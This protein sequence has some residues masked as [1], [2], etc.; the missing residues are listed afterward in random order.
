MKSLLIII[1]T[2][3]FSIYISA[4]E[5]NH[6]LVVYF[7][8][9]DE[10]PYTIEKPSDFLTK[11]AIERREKYNIPI[12][13]SDLPVVPNYLE[14]LLSKKIALKIFYTSRWMN[15]AVVKPHSDWKLN[16]NQIWIK[17]V[18]EY[19]IISKSKT[20]SYDENMQPVFPHIYDTITNPY[21][22]QIKLDKLHRMG[23]TGKGI[24]IAVFDA[25]FSYMQRHRIF[26]PLFNENRV[27][28]T[29]DFVSFSDN[30]YTYHS[31]G[32]H[33]TALLAA[34]APDRYVGSAPD[35]EY[36]LIRIDDINTESIIEEYNWLAAAEYADSLGVDV[37]NASLGFIDF[38]DAED[39]KTTDLNGRTAISS[40]SAGMAAAKGIAV[41]VSAG[42]EGENGFWSRYITFPADNPDVIAVGS[43]NE[44]GE[45]SAFSSLG[46]RSSICE[47]IKPDL[48]ARGENVYVPSPSPTSDLGEFLET[49]G[50]T[51]YSAPLIA[52]GIA[53]LLQNFPNKTPKEIV[54]ALK[55]SGSNS[56]DPDR[57]IGWGIPDFYF[58]YRDLNKLKPEFEND[59]IKINYIVHQP[60][61]QTIEINLTS[62]NNCILTVNIYDT[63]GRLLYVQQYKIL[64][65]RMEYISI[66]V[67]FTV[68]PEIVILTIQDEKNIL[69]KRK[70]LIL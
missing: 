67:Q 16:I 58:A 3:C 62:I 24:R 40:I 30:I 54:T 66:D 56:F 26:D 9:K 29:K 19:G 13:F 55:Q 52:G 35:A 2:F 49:K 69:I 39:Y 45:R 44:S 42:N 36:I 59:N 11:R 21:L 51:S 60:F 4:Q 68:K 22:N 43:V 41:I 32:M 38:D 57:F 64:Y 34:N 7:K 5:Q 1:I 27:I 20:K 15:L 18:K 53:C 12:D 14:L 46:P 50:G 31:H 70:I 33:V 23:F 17:E 61:N 25:G 37:I 10:T 48:L 8:G 28:A 63:L 65:D 47:Y 6:Y